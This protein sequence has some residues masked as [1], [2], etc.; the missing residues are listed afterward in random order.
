MLNG[1]SGEVANSVRG[2]TDGIGE[3]S[4][5]IDQA[6]VGTD[7]VSRH[8]SDVEVIARETS[9]TA[10]QISHAAADLAKQSDYLKVE[11]QQF[12]ESVRAGNQ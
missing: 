5:N 8:I 9:G 6:S 1:I 3:I 11:V 10:V 2:Q 4:R 12:L 7:E